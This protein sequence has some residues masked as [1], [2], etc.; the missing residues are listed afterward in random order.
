VAHRPVEQGGCIS[1]HD[2][3]GSVKAE[4]LLKQE[5]KALCLSCHKPNA[6]G[7]SKAHGNYAVAQTRCTGCHD[8][9]GSDRKGMLYNTVHKP[10]ASA[11]C[12]ECHT[13]ASPGKP[14]MLKAQGVAL[15]N[16]CHKQQIATMLGKARVHQAVVDPAACL[17]C[18]SPHAARERGLLRGKLT[19]VCGTCH[20]DTIS[21]QDRSVT[22]HAPV[23]DGSCATCHDPHSS[24]N[25][26]MMK[27]ASTIDQCGTCH[28]Y[29]KHSSHPIG[30]KLK[31]PRNR[32]LK[33]DCLSCHRAHGTEYKHMVPFPSTTD[34]CVKCHERFKR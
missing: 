32:N 22:P 33:L 28:D 4:H 27:K 12:T 15:C 11:Q 14:A 2:A 9:H 26:L 1:C 8:P 16:D 19:Q 29:Q 24:E 13:P 23:R 20:A 5:E 17:N 7:F 25:V 30:D 3:H 18:H 34:L 21:R 10:V 6:Q 31:D